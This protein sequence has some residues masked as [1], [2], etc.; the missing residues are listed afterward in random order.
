ME[1][2]DWEALPPYSH[3]AIP[4]PLLTLQSIPDFQEFSEDPHFLAFPPKGQPQVPSTASKACLPPFSSIP[5]FQM[6]SCKESLPKDSADIHSVNVRLAGR[7]IQGAGNAG[8]IS[9]A[10]C[11]VFLSLF[12]FKLVFCNPHDEW[13]EEAYLEFGRIQTYFARR[14]SR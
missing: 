10:P 13:F 1:H 2:L 3:W 11:I 12:V 7:P 14:Y 5:P 8:D 6:A 9:H 4:P